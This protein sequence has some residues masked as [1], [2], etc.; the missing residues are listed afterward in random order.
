MD[1]FEFHAVTP[2]GD[3]IHGTLS[4][5]NEVAAKQELARRE[6]RVITLVRHESDVAGELSEDAVDVLLQEIGGAAAGRIP[7]EVSLGALAEENSDPRLAAVAERLATRLEQGATIDEALKE[8]EGQLP[9]EIAGL[10][11]SGVQSGDLAG[12][13]ERFSQQRLAASRYNRRIRA[14]LAYPLIIVAIL[15]PTLL[16]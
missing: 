3:E 13:F 6:L 15:V 4:A 16:F 9:T 1:H 2:T 10:L 11:R 12:M 8:V 5:A 7:L 14:T